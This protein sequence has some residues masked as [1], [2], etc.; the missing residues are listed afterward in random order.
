MSHQGRV[1]VPRLH[2]ENLG[3]AVSMRSILPSTGVFRFWWLNW[4]S[5]RISWNN[6]LEIIIIH[7]R[8]SLFEDQARIQKVT[9]EKRK[10]ETKGREKVEADGASACPPGTFYSVGFFPHYLQ[11]NEALFPPSP[12][13]ACQIKT[14]YIWLACWLSRNCVRLMTLNFSVHPVGFRDVFTNRRVTEFPPRRTISNPS[15]AVKTQK[16]PP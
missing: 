6:P 2:F 10:P 13:A 16:P 5:S 7:P 8:G 4:C 3:C 12:R 9:T 11:Q 14:S 15:T 1:T